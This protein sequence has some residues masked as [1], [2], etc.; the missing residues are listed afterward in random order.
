MP[1]CPSCPQ[2]AT[3]PVLCAPRQ[4]SRA[5]TGCAQHWPYS[6][7]QGQACNQALPIANPSGIARALA[8]CRRMQ[9]CALCWQALPELK[10][11][12]ARPPP[13]DPPREG[14][15]N[16]GLSEKDHIPAQ[17][18]ATRA[19]GHL[20]PLTGAFQSRALPTTLLRLDFLSQ[21][22]V[23]LLRLTYFLGWVHASSLITSFVGQSHDSCSD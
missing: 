12:G 3:A 7:G 19:G 18:T 9:A 15:M 11:P 13:A 5:S 14:L 1:A 2:A 22:C 21:G 16:G 10:G 17:V 6:R 20:P 4:P 23:S 8:S